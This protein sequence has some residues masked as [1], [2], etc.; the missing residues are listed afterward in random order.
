M[1][2][3]PVADSRGSLRPTAPPARKEETARSHFFRMGHGRIRAEEEDGKMM[4][5]NGDGVWGWPD[6]IEPTQSYLV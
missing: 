6:M 4:S 2:P 5:P 3:P 1:Y